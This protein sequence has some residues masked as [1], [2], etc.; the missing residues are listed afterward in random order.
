[1]ACTTTLWLG[2]SS[3][4]LLLAPKR[5]QKEKTESGRTTDCFS[6]DRNIHMI[7]IIFHFRFKYF[8][9]D[10]S[11]RPPDPAPDHLYVPRFT[12]TPPFYTLYPTANQTTPVSLA[13]KQTTPMPGVHGERVAYLSL[14]SIN[15]YFN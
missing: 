1:M 8:P 15:K 7:L 5:T 2:G 14:L 12:L 13:E 3:G 6:P 10:N 4:K 9:Y 11:Q